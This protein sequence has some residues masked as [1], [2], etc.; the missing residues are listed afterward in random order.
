MNWNN[1]EYKRIFDNPL[2]WLCYYAA[3]FLLV[4]IIVGVFESRHQGIARSTVLA[5]SD[6]FFGGFTHFHA[7]NGGLL[8]QLRNKRLLRCNIGHSCSGCSQSIDILGC[9]KTNLNIKTGHKW[10]FCLNS[11]YAIIYQI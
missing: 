5:V 8:S 6:E 11:N 3:R 7:L 9:A 1:A 2:I 10:L 4:W